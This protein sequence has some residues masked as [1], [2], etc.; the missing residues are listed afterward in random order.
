MGAGNHHHLARR[1]VRAGVCPSK[2]GMGPVV[3]GLCH[4]GAV[5]TGLAPLTADAAPHFATIAL[6]RAFDQ[7]AGCHFGDQGDHRG[8]NGLMRPPSSIAKPDHLDPL[9]GV[10]NR[11]AATIPHDIDARCTQ[12]FRCR[13]GT[14]SSQSKEKGKA[15]HSTNLARAG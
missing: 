5:G 7:F 2:P 13:L 12:K 4:F 6:Q 10:V 14:A 9:L 11:I 15:F 3:R 1:D 8:A